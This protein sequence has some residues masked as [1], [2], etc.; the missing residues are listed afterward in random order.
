MDKQLLVS[1]KY[2]FVFQFLVVC[3]L[4]AKNCISFMAFSIGER[5][6]L[7]TKCFEG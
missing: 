7:L 6:D 3:E 1:I 5:N 4:V 2:L